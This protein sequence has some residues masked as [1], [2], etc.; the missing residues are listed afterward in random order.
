MPAHRSQVGQV[1]LADEN[2]KLLVGGLLVEV[3]RHTS[4]RGHPA[5]YHLAYDCSGA[6]TAYLLRSHRTIYVPAGQHGHR[7]RLN[8]AAGWGQ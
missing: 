5:A 2:G 1:F 8:I 7:H 6:A 4:G 3:Q